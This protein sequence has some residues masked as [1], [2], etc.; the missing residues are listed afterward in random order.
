MWSEYVYVIFMCLGW[1]NLW[2]VESFFMLN[3]YILYDFCIEIKW[4]GIGFFF[5]GFVRCL[6]CS[7]NS[8]FIS[9]KKGLI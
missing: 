8:L 2:G 3:G 1:S 7:R 5:V 9:R 6:R 4:D